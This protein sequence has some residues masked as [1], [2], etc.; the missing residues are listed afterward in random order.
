MVDDLRS[1]LTDQL[2]GKNVHH[3]SWKL[4]VKSISVAVFA[5]DRSTRHLLVAKLRSRK[6]L[7][8][9]VAPNCHHWSVKLATHVDIRPSDEFLLLVKARHRPSLSTTS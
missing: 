8:E 9:S 4:R 3:W 5:H 1:R 2:R 6:R 7:A